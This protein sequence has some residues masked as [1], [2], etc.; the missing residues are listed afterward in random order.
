MA[1][2][3]SDCYSDDGVWRRTIRAW[4]GEPITGSP[5]VGGVQRFEFPSGG[6]VGSSHERTI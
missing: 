4:E 6:G 2:E 1:S 5:L 3:G